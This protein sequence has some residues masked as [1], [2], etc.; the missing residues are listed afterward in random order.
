MAFAG[1]FW[2][3]TDTIRHHQC[4]MLSGDVGRMSQEFLI[5]Y[6]SAVYGRV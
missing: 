2:G 5:G 3:L 6:L 4:V 1:V